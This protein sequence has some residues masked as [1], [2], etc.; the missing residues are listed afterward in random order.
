[1]SKF[2]K[3]SEL[4]KKI[5]ILRV[6]ILISVCM[7]IA[8]EVIDS[9]CVVG[10]DVVISQ[11]V[12]G[13]G[14][15]NESGVNYYVP[16]K[17]IRVTILFRKNQVTLY[18]LGLESLIPSGW[19]YLGLVPGNYN[20]SVSPT[21]NTISDGVSPLEFAWINTT[22]L[23]EEFSI[24]Y[25]VEVPL[26]ESGGVNIVSRGLYRLTGGQICTNTEEIMF[27]GS[28]STSEGEGGIEG[29]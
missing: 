12:S 13:E 26:D 4:D 8:G 17:T 29:R 23:P 24:S 15:V 28:Y 2:K 22:T 16:G 9:D 7:E 19:K 25:D 3:I 14:V 20:P 5:I 18:A 21:A 27:V 1:M 6:I 11:S 10:T